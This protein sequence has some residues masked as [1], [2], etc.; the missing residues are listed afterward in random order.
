MYAT[1][2]LCFDSQYMYTVM[3]YLVFYYTV[4]YIYI[5]NKSQLSKVAF[6]LS[7]LRWA[8]RFSVI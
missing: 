4:L 5:L 7:P 2:L 1:L 3:T 6:S 8:S